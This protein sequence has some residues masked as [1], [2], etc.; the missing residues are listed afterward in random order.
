MAVMSLLGQE[1]WQN[2]VFMTVLYEVY[3]KDNII[4]DYESGP[5]PKGTITY[6]LMV[7][8]DHWTVGCLSNSF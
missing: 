8:E 3:M 4:D 7:W 1:Y 6:S 5:F 2:F